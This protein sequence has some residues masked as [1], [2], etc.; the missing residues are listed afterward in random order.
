MKK[1]SKK[2]TNQMKKDV[3]NIIGIVMLHKMDSE[4]YTQKDVAK[5]LDYIWNEVD[6]LIDEL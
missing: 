5:L 4:N 6:K 2:E 1:L 3:A